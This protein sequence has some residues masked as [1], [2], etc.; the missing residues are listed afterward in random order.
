MLQ[1]PTIG[2]TITVTTRFLHRNFHSLDD[3]AEYTHTGTVLP[4]PKWLTPDQFAVSNPKHP[5]GFSV[6][7]MSHVVDLRDTNGKTV[8]ISLPNDDYK[9]WIMLGSKG[10]TYLVIRTKGQYNCTCPG[11]TYRKHCRHITEVGNE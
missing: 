2:S 8:S 9:E 7:T 3:Y 6:F 4:D 10:N 1:K 11:F 5:N